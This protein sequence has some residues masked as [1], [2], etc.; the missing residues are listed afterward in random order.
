M[1]IHRRKELHRKRAT[2]NR[3]RPACSTRSNTDKRYHTHIVMPPV[4]A[5]APCE[6][7]GE[8]GYFI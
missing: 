8:G 1:R 6:G 2:R 7:E 5:D 4:P 3:S